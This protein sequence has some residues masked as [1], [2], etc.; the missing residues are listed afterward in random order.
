M[1]NINHELAK[2]LNGHQKGVF[3]EHSLCPYCGYGDDCLDIVPAWQQGEIEEDQ[4]QSIDFWC[5]CTCGKTWVM[6][7]KL[8]EIY[9]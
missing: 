3:T 6:R 1:I 5:S 4:Y 7:F 8:F 2:P 9:G